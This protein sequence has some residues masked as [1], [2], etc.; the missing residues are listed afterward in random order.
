[1]VLW[2]DS[3]VFRGVISEW[4]S[5]VIMC[6]GAIVVLSIFQQQQ[7]DHER[8]RRSGEIEGER[9]RKKKK[10]KEE[11]RERYLGSLD[12]VA[13][14]HAHLDT[15]LAGLFDREQNALALGVNL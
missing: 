7:N 4:Y 15:G 3:V 5:S 2:C 1:M 8:S 10:K 14:D 11:K 12:V 6:S 13:C 9:E